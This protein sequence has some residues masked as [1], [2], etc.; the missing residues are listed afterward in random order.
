MVQ[1]TG[2][3]DNFYKLKLATDI[4]G[5]VNVDSVTLLPPGTAVPEGN[6]SYITVDSTGDGIRV[7]L[8]VGMK[9]PYEI[10][11]DLSPQRLDV[12]IFGVIG[13]VDWIR[14]NTK[15][16]LIKIVKWSQPQDHVFRLTVEI[17]NGRLW[18]YKAF[19][20]DT[21]F[22]LII[23]EEPKLHGSLSKRLKGLKV[24]ID[25]GH[26]QDPGAIGPTGLLEKDANLW[27]AHKL[28]VMLEARGAKVLMTRYGHENVSLYDR[29]LKADKWG[30]D[31]LVSIH[32]NALPDG[33]NPFYN[34]G[35]SVYY[36]Y[37]HSK[38]LAETIH[39]AM[40]KRTG[41]PDHGLY[42]GNLVLPRYN[43]A[44]AVLVECTFMIIPGQEALLKTAS[45][46][47]K[48]ARAILDGITDYIA[49]KE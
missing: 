35:T 47:K 20:E 27:I 22:I 21:K 13:S 4:P 14:Y 18:G 31:L 29:P 19:Y 37:P 39:N 36:Y 11:E 15:N 6:A 46:Q 34:N 16:P 24:A 45:F 5:Y 26:S 10:N 44:P 38:A 32:N 49:Q 25:P 48:C 28:R 17:G 7:A 42:Y 9:L 1:V 30:A 12:D 43:F 40:L 2:M 8:D 41:L 23:R 3:R 33:I